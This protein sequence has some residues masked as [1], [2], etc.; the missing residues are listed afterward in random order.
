L[1][2]FAR[3][4]GDANLPNDHGNNWNLGMTYSMPWGQQSDKANYRSTLANLRSSKVRLDQLEQTLVVNVRTAV[5]AVETNLVAVEIAA[6]ATELSAKQYDLQKAR[7][8]AGL[9]T[10][11]LVLQAQDDLE[12]ARFNELGAKVALR[13]AVVEVNRLEGSSL[14]RY[15]VQLPQ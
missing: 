8:D 12:T 5:R 15:R 6:K 4:Y 10:A 7:F 9:S 1:H 14:T 11:R 3:L 13:Q 2:W